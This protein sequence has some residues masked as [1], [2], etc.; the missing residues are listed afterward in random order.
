MPRTPEDRAREQI[1]ALL[2]DAG[3]AVQDRDSVNLGA[4]RGIAVREFPLARG[5]GTA[6][7]LLYGDRRALGVIE[8]KQEGETLA[9]VEVQ[10]EKYGAGLPAGLPAWRSPL[11]FLYQCSSIWTYRCP[12]LAEQH[13][14]V[15]EVERR[16][17]IIDET[18][19]IVN[20][21]RK[22]AERLRQASLKRAFE[23]RL[24]PQDP[25]DEPAGV[26]LERIRAERAVNGKAPKN[27]RGRVKTRA[28]Q[29]AL[30]LGV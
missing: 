8:A 3:W 14:I 16:L 24:V 11:P 10:T 9:G 19:A 4:A 13:R 12:P 18:E 28:G 30:H 29:S 21:N 2:I 23:G 5:H 25:S 7:Y 6:D 17:S 22:R 27:G 20:A 26:L 1:D 15:A